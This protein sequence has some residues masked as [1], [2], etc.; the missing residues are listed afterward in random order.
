MTAFGARSPMGGIDGDGYRPYEGITADTPEEVDIIFDHAEVYLL[1]L[2][3]NIRYL[4]V[5]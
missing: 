2:L 1:H 5:Y 3:F 4:S